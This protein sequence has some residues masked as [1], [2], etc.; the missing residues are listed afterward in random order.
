M[1]RLR[2]AFVVSLLA[3]LMFG[4]VSPVHAQEGVTS[5]LSISTD[6]PSMV[7]GMG[8]MVT[9][10]LDI[11]S[12]SSQVI[13]LD[14]SGLPAGWTAEFRGGGRV[15]QSVFIDEDLTS[16]V[17]LRITPGAD[18]SPGTYTITVIAKGSGATAQFPV[19]FT[20]KDKLPAQL[21]FESEF[22]TIRSGS[23]STFTFSATLR[24]SGDEDVTVV[25]SADAP[26]EFAVTFKSSGKDI[27]NLPTDIRSGGSQ[28]ISVE[29][30]PLTTLPVGKYPITVTAQGESI[31]ATLSLIAEVVGQPQLTIT[32]PDGRLSG[33]ATLGRTTPIKLILRNSGNS[34]AVGINLTATSPA[35]WTVQLD[36]EQV[37]EV[38]ANGEVEVTANVTPSDQALAGDYMLTFRAQPKEGT[39]KTADFRVTVKTSTLWGVAGIGLIAAAVVIVGLAVVRFG[40]R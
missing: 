28:T 33:E 18:T 8:E 40:R 26:R 30:A 6:Y 2:F 10:S 1:N 34:P 24:N 14:V 27:T 31:D 9:V 3:G 20:V 11:R 15:I 16:T 36:P 22:P 12:P 17:D 13:D 4:L 38:P 5:P 35:G 37:I 29:A 23:N 21:S 19:E 25:L 7:I 39:S 32:A